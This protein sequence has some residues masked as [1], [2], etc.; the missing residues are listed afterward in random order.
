MFFYNLERITGNYGKSMS[1]KM[2]KVNTVLPV[3]G[4]R[5]GFVD[6]LRGFALVV[7]IEVHVTNAYL[8]LAL[9]KGSEFF[10]WLAFINGLVA[11]TFLFAAGFSI[12]LLGN[13][14]WDNWL[15][16]GPSF[17]K[18]MRR[19]GFITLAAYY[20]H[21]QGFRLSHYLANW[22][23]YTIWSRS[24]K[25]DVLQCIVV[26]LLVVHALIFIVRKKKYFPWG[27]LIL[28]IFV[29]VSTPWVWAQDFRDQLPLSVA[30]LL[31]PHGMSL[32]PVFPWLCF[33]LAG[34]FTSSLFLKAVEAQ[35]TARFMRWIAWFGALMVAGG[36]LLRGVPFTL[37]GNV[38]F[39]TT[40][41]LYLMIRI[42]CV[43]VL[44]FL[45]YRWEVRGKWIPTLV[46]V[47]GQES[48]LVYGVHLWMIFGLLR[49]RLLAQHLPL[50]FGYA[51]C[52]SLSIVLV[53]LMLCL[54]KYYHKLK[55]GY[56]QRVRYA[57]GIIV[58]LMILVF[59]LS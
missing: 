24:L 56:P 42:G 35:K 29:A 27:A 25:A 51:G 2:A 45:L 8:P 57:Q 31:N 14:Q 54:A 10:F 13:S 40:S 3:K 5:Y 23:D 34:S 12:V 59:V 52:F 46:Q 50:Q 22:N 41:P 30:F 26:S 58:I 20:T 37:P 16:F 38:N 1:K 18:Q 7:M 39:Y 48:L 21:V 17:W 11:P 19:I 15:R 9:K 4:P 53:L 43:L 32:F 47:A 44:C 28:A 55:S 36:L 49:G 6:L 33:V